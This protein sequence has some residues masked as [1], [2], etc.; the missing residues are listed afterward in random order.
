MEEKKHNFPVMSDEE[1]AKALEMAR[2]TVQIKKAIS[3]GW[4]QHWTDEGLWAI[5]RSHAG[6]RAFPSY[7]HSSETKYIRRTLKAIHKDL[8]WY[9]GNFCSSL[10]EFGEKN[11]LVPAYVLQGLML[12]A[13]F[14]EIANKQQ[15]GENDE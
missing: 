14:P 9:K 12:E 7:V 13:A 3:Q 8:D 15:A 11:P 1:R 5:L 6:V 4:K 2:E 10:N